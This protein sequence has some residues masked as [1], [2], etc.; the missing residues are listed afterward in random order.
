MEKNLLFL[1]V[2]I[3]LAIGVTSCA[4]TQ[5]S[6]EVEKHTS[7]RFVRIEHNTAAYNVVY[8]K[9]TRVMYAVSAGPHNYGHFT[10]LVDAEG[11]PLL[12]NK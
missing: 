4:P 11:K 1:L 5:T 7:S 8:D 2:V 6:S 9:E 12:Y 10:L 3:L